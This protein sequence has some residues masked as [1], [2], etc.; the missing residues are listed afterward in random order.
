MLKMPFFYL[1]YSYYTLIPLKLKK[2]KKKK[3]F[4]YTKKKKKTQ[5][6]GLIQLIFFLINAK[7]VHVIGLN[8]K[9]PPMV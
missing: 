4:L 5:G 2:R 6:C 1:L 8:Y 7:L 9:S 3:L